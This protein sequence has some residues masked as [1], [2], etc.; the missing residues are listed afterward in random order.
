VKSL[1]HIFQPAGRKAEDRSYVIR[2]AL[3]GDVEELGDLGHEFTLPSR[4][5]SLPKAKPSP[6]PPAT[7]DDGHHHGRRISVSLRLISHLR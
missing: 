6:F 5:S 3:F 4:L 2:H 1:R 7:D